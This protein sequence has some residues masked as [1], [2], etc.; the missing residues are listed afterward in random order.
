MKVIS[1]FFNTNTALEMK[2]IAVGAEYR[3]IRGLRET[4]D[5]QTLDVWGIFPD[6][7]K[8]SSKGAEEFR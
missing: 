5:Y 3:K 8:H 7:L 1:A 2:L 4:A 6:L